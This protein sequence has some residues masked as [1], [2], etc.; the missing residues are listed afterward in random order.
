MNSL[1]ASDFGGFGAFAATVTPFAEARLPDVRE[2]PQAREPV[3]FADIVGQ[4]EILDLLRLEIAASRR[5]GRRLTDVLI[6]GPPGL[7]KTMLCTAIANEAE[8]AIFPVTGPELATTDAAL[9]ILAGCGRLHE[10]TNRPV[11]L[12]LDEAD[13]VPRQVSYLLHSIMLTGTISWR[14]EVY[15]MVPLTILATSNRLAKI[16]PAMRSRFSEVLY[17]DYYAVADLE[18]IA[19]R[20]GPEL[21]NGVAHYLAENS[22][23]EPRKIGHLLRSLRNVLDGRP[24]ATMEDAQRALKLSGLRALGLSR[25][26]VRY[27]ETLASA[28][29]TMMGLNS[30]AGV[31]GTDVLEIVGAVEPFLLRSQLSQVTRSGRKLTAKGLQYLSSPN[32]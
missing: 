29:D 4:P 8:C 10:G 25:L 12:V 18:T 20:D 30:I 9:Q 2:F 28:P 22:G 19:T 6:T 5:E 14:G 24:A 3:G 1:E 31:L 13:A 11:A 17:L 32:L 26:Q 15:G 21:A 23:G 16:P 7:G 27:L